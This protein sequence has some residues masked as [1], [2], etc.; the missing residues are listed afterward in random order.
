[1]SFC[2]L[3][4]LR[5]VG[6][7]TTEFGSTITGAGR[8]VPSPGRDVFLSVEAS[9]A[10]L[11]SRVDADSGAVGDWAGRGVNFHATAAMV[12]SAMKT[13]IAAIRS[14]LRD[15]AGAAWAQGLGE[16]FRTGSTTLG[17][18][19]QALFSSSA[20]ALQGLAALTPPLR[21]PQRLLS[22]PKKLSIPSLNV[23]L[24][25]PCGTMLPSLARSG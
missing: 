18:A 24:S 8:G 1:M 22:R 15:A 16:I 11:M 12:A 2:K 6:L 4:P 17:G 20:Q 21:G 13:A 7:V 5:N 10:G 14:T 23:A 9:L 3:N 25:R 19:A